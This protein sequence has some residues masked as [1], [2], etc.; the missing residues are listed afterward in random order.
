MAS[1][2][3]LV[4]YQ[5][6]GFDMFTN[7]MGGIKEE[8]VGYLFNLS[9]ELEDDEDDAPEAEVIEPMRQSVPDIPSAEDES[10]APP[11]VFEKQPHFRAPGLDR[12]KQPQHLAYSAPREGVGEIGDDDV[13][14]RSEAVAGDDEFAG[15]GRNSLCPCGSGKKFKR[16]HGAPGGPSGLKARVN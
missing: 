14:V 1:A 9:V 2:I 13:E 15:V 10:A 5:R 7:M 16:C 8:V 6:E 11:S 4:E 12:P 3:P